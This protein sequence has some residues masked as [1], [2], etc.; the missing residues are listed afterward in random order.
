MHVWRADLDAGGERAAGL[1]LLLTPDERARAEGVLGARER[2]RWARSRGLLRELLGRY[3][4]SDPRELRFR[5]GAH[6]KPALRGARS[7]PAFNVSHSGATMLLAFSAAGAVGVDVEA[8]DCRSAGRPRNDVAVAERA[9][10][11]FEA[12]RLAAL[13]P[14]AREAELLRLWTRHE[15]Q[16]KR[17]GSGIG[18]GL[19]HGTP[20]AGWVAELDLGPGH[21]GAVALAHEPREL[22]LLQWRS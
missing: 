2:A 4:G 11:A 17:R 21:A 16:L 1:E 9:F 15:A 6:G 3:T 7:A 10:G 5:S 14:R 13:R 12:E 18:A 20:L 8:A 19:Q 22:R